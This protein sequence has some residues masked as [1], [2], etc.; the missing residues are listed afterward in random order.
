MTIALTQVETVAL[1]TGL[2]AG[3][4]SIVLSVVAILFAHNVDQRSSEVS[5]QTIRSLE[6]IQSTVERLSADTGGLIKVAWDRM[7]VGAIG[8]TSPEADTDLR[9]AMSGLLAELRQEVGEVAPGTEL[10]RLTVE[11]GDR[12]RDGS[13]S[14]EPTRRPTGAFN[15]AARSIESLSPISTEL[16]RALTDEHAHLT[17]AQYKRLRANPGLKLA[18]EELR[19]RDLVVPLAGRNESDEEETVYWLAPWF[20]D[21]IGPALVFTGH[22]RPTDNEAAHVHAALREVGYFDD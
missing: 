9:A 10:E 14:E 8:A 17:R 16:L 7:L 19:A 22:E 2:L 21:V 11:A 18:L 13:D 3:V 5:N 6:S 20:H 12:V 15:A 4:V 1:W